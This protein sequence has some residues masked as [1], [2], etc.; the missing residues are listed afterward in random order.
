M[1]RLTTCGCGAQREV[2]PE[3]NMDLQPLESLTSSTT[4][5]GAWTDG[6]IKCMEKAV[7]SWNGISPVGNSVLCYMMPGESFV[8]IGRMTPKEWQLHVQRDHLPFRRDCRH[9]V[10][11]ASGRPHRRITH[12]S[13]Y[14][15]SADVA[16][17]FRSRGKSTDTNQHRF[18]LVCAYQFPRLP[19]TSE[20]QTES[21]DEDRGAG[22]GEVFL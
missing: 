16:G 7:V 13:A 2:L 22:I 9:C 11:A 19:G 21:V 12:R 14:V 20:K 10:Q 3:R 15:L 8:R 4:S 17:P 6:Y 18:M 5:G 1:R